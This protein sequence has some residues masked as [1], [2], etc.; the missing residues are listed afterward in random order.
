MHVKMPSGARKPAQPQVMIR[1]RFLLR[2]LVVRDLKSRYAGSLFGFFWA[3][4]HP[5]WQLALFT[6]VFSYILRIPLVG[7]RTSSF[8]LF[9]FAGLLPWLGVQEGISRATTA[10]S[11]GAN[12]VKKLHFP[13]EILVLGVVLAAFAH[14]A[15]ALVLFGVLQAVRGDLVFAN[16]PWL[17]LGG[18]LQLG[19]TFG[20]GLAA[21]ALQVFFRDVVQL[22]GVVTPA[23]FY[24]TPIVYAPGWVPEAFSRWVAYNPLATIVQLYRCALLGSDTPSA[25]ATALACAATAGALGLGLAIFRRLS[26]GFS[27]EL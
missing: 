18:V 20:I 25:F 4:L 12:L 15:V 26:P 5:L 1:F 7:E 19:L 17:A 2:E 14:Q 27:D 13:S 8:P 3:F 21:A 24:L 6:V 16:L 9:L 23:W 11:E 22:V 10:I